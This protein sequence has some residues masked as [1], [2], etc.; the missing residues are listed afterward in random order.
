MSIPFYFAMEENEATPQ[1][2]LNYAQL[3]FGFSENGMLR[4]PRQRI[5]NAPAVINDRILPDKAPDAN[6]LDELAEACGSGCFL[7]F[8]RQISKVS[9]AI[10]VGLMQRL[11]GNMTVP[12]AFHRICPD[13]NVQIPSIL[14]NNWESF[15][16]TVQ[17]QYGARWVLEIIPWKY[18]VIT[19]W[20][21]EKAGDLSAATCKYRVKSGSICY[22]DTKETIKAKLAIAEAYGCQAGIT[23]LREYR[24]VNLKGAQLD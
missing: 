14:C 6:L 5:L 15:I 1:A 22:Y 17:T 16:K 9:A 20:K 19:P 7:D 13:A 8:E 21:E 2:E 4:L 12:P 11:H 3:G 10:A 23:L 18:I 24:Q